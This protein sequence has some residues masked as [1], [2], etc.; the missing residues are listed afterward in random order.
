[1]N[2]AK[3][4]T[5]VKPSTGVP[6]LL[7]AVAVTALIVHAGLLANTDW[8]ANYFNGKPMTAVVAV[9]APAQ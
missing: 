1:M 7:G 5:V 6:L 9:A 4:W 3:L 8:F 2:N